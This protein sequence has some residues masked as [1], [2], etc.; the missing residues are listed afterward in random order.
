MNTRSL[1]RAR[2][3]VNEGLRLTVYD[4]ATGKPITKG[5]VVKGF[6][7][8]GYGCRVDEPILEAEA[9]RMLDARMDA[10][11]VETDARFPWVV[12]LDPT[13]RSVIYEMAYQMGVAGLAKFTRTLALIRRG[14][15]EAG[16]AAMLQSKWA[17][18][19]TPARAQRLSR[20][21]ETGECEG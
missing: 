11:I 4:D 21:M 15:Y 1:L 12:S 20:I 10:K 3:Q 18:V 17:R 2:L 8:I 7:T 19:Q 5:S 9:G 13:R 16:A 6:P 14:E